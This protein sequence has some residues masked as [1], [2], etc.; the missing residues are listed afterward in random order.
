[1]QGL[2]AVAE[3]LKE[4]H[5]EATQQEEVGDDIHKL[6]RKVHR[7]INKEKKR[8]EMEVVLATDV[9]YIAT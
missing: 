5:H 6:S 2:E 1:M 7:G 8:E 4:I 9:E 3:N